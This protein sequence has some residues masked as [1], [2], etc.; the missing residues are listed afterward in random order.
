ME[1]ALNF[2]IPKKSIYNDY[3]ILMASQWGTNSYFDNEKIQICA[4]E[5]MT[6]AYG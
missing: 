4:I 3:N 5:I 6:S 1:T 2:T